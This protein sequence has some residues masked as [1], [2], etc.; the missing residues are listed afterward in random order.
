M[1]KAK[2][3]SD[4]LWVLSGPIIW[5]VHFFSIYLVEALLCTASMPSGSAMTAATSILTGAA[6]LAMFAIV[7]HRIP[8]SEIGLNSAHDEKGFLAFLTAILVILSAL[9]VIWV[10][11]PG[12]WLSV[13]AFV[14]S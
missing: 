7:A 11:I 2:P 10:T 9:A 6:L 4:F 8:L 12:V 3:I 1:H 13:C 14:R 5:A